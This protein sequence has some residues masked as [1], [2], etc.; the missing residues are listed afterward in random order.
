M[1]HI[2]FTIY[3]DPLLPRNV[4]TLKCSA[5]VF[6]VAVN[7]WDS[8]VNNL[9]S[10]GNGTRTLLIVR[11]GEC[12]TLFNS[13]SLSVTLRNAK[14]TTSQTGAKFKQK[15]QSYHDQLNGLSNPSV[16]QPTSPFLRHDRP[17]TCLF[18]V[19]WPNKTIVPG[20]LRHHHH[21][22]IIAYFVSVW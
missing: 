10:R 2:L 3:Y 16:P 21:I 9:G 7:G 17:L 1:N 18:A 15:S 4:S 14:A 20:R 22:T 5:S 13:R 19:L 8:R 12:W 11:F 6:M